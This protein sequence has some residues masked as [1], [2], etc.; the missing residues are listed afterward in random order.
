MKFKYKRFRLLP[1]SAFPQRKY[2]LRPIIPVL[3]GY[4]EK[5]IGYEALL[6]SG[7]D[8]CIFHAEIGEYLGIPV[9]DGKKEFFGG[10]TSGNAVAFVHKVNLT[11]GGNS[12]PEIS[13]GFSFDIAPHGYGILGQEGFFNFFRV[14][15]DLEKEEIELRPKLIS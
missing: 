4:G 10:V 14:G 15:F 3:I 6:D 5:Q 12:Y 9:L 13:I 11:I 2:L 8:F 7:A 1:T